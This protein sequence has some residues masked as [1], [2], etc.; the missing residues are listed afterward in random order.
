MQTAVIEAG[1]KAVGTEIANK[2]KQIASRK[3]AIDAEI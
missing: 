1:N 3:D 2:N